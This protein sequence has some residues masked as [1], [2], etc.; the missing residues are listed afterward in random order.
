MTIYE[1]LC[2]RAQCHEGASSSKGLCAKLC[3]YDRAGLC[4]EK[5]KYMYY[6]QGVLSEHRHRFCQP[7]PLSPARQDTVNRHDGQAQYAPLALPH[8]IGELPSQTTR[9]TLRHSNFSLLHP[10]LVVKKMYFHLALVT[11]GILFN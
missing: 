1:D 3:M 9:C 5:K 8:Q 6:R 2:I 7:Q 10:S 11:Q 4:S